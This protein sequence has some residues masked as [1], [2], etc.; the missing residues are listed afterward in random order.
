MDGVSVAASVVSFVSLGIQVTQGLVDFYS[1]HKSR[2]SD[3][4][5]TLKKL[6][7]LAVVLEALR[8]QL[9]DRKFRADEQEL[10]R[11]IDASVQDCKDC[12]KEL[13]SEADKFKG[14]SSTS[15]RA[16]ARTVAY[17]ATY[18]FRQST[19][20]K[21]GEDIDEIVAHVSLALQVLDHSDTRHIQHDVED[22]KALLDL[23]RADQ[24]SSTLR[25][26]LNAPDPSDNYNKAREKCHPGTGLWFVES[27]SF[28]SWLT[29]PHSF[30]WLNGFAGCG[31]SVLCSTAIRHVHRHRRS[32]P[33]IGIA[34][35]FFR[36]DDNSKQD[37]SALLRTLVLQLSSQLN[38]SQGHLA[39]LHGSYRGTKPPNQALLDCLHQL[40]RAFDHVYILLDALDES[41]QSEHRGDVLQ[42]LSDIRAWRE[43]GLHILVTSRDEI[44]IREDLEALEQE[45]ISLRNDYVD[46][47]IAA[48]VSKYLRQNRRLQ[49]WEKHYDQIEKALTDRAKGVF[50][51]VECQFTALE[52]CPRSKRSLD[53]LL[54]SLPRSL[55]KTY[56]R[57]LLNISEESVDD[58][59]RILT[60]LC[61]AK[62]PLTVGE[63]IEGVAVE[64]GD[65]PRLNPDGRLLD[66]TE[67]RRVCPGLIELVSGEQT[68]V[69]LAHF[70]VQE[71]LESERMHSSVAMFTVKKIEANSEMA[72]ICLTYLM[73][74]VL[75]ISHRRMFPLA[76]Y[77]AANWCKHFRDGD[78]SLHGARSRALELFQSTTGAFDNWVRLASSMNSILRPSGKPSPVYSTSVLG[79]DS[80]LSD[81]FTAL[82]ASSLSEFHA[83]INSVCGVLGNALQAASWVGHE[84]TVRLLLD[85]GADVNASGS[86]HDWATLQAAS[87]Y[88]HEAVV[89][90]LLEKGAAVNIQGSP[91][92]GTALQ[93]A[94]SSG[95]KAIVRLLLERGADINA[96]SHYEGTALQLASWMGHGAIVRLLLDMGADVNAQG[97]YGHGTALQI[98]S[99]YGN[100]A[101][102]RLLLENGAEVMRE[103]VGLV[104]APYDWHRTADIVDYFGSILQTAAARSHEASVQLLLDHGVDINAYGGITGLH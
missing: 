2:T 36:F 20:L 6:Q 4:A 46:K 39:R 28:K 55:D 98:A 30:L 92:C 93:A 48:F 82:P 87:V 25:Q 81:W 74:P 47:D 17:R 99:E 54:A 78:I 18:P 95:N 80:V 13:Q 79:L 40:V 16:T 22:I 72:S 94:S 73:D 85:M 65:N 100:E 58:A 67:L 41:P 12:M 19:L 102:V 61:C 62:R 27:S 34:F 8:T 14:G 76:L 68:T 42:A 91:Y 88:G 59:K 66:E 84:A 11:S 53:R 97:S 9:A 63:V 37:T 10:L 50:R 24:V 96:Q 86:D 104:I 90:L 1:A 52:S 57:M 21:L 64:L 89:R 38:D 51:W 75:L 103:V 49:G 70:S 26:W 29:D 83:N 15:I 32:S 7:H 43:P 5:H 44:D 23:V 45:T 31:K 101:V 60:L 3:V 33:R 71:Y 56:E 77:A 69:R 35:F